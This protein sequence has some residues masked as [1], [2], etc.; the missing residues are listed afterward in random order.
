[1]AATYVP[2]PTE[3]LLSRQRAKAAATRKRISDARANG[4][5]GVMTRAELAAQCLRQQRDN[6]S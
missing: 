6:A 1:M 4:Y 3:M 2:T 5:R